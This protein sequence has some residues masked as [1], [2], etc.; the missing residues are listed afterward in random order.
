MEDKWTFLTHGDEMNVPVSPYLKDIQVLVCK[1]KLIE[2]GMGIHFF[3]NAAAGGNYILQPSF[4]NAFWLASLLP[5]NAPLSTMRIITTS[6]Y[7]LSEEYPIKKSMSLLTATKNLLDVVE[8]KEQV[9]GEET[10]GKVG[11]KSSG[12]GILT[13]D[14]MN[15]LVTEALD[16]HNSVVD[17]SSIMKTVISEESSMRIRNYTSGTPHS[18]A[19][20]HDP[21]LVASSSTS[22]QDIEHEKEQIAK[23]IRAETAVLRL[24]R[25]NAATDHSSII[26]NVDL[27]TGVI[28]YGTTNS[29]WYQ[30]GVWKIIQQLVINSANSLWL[31]IKQ[32]RNM[33][34]HMDAPQP[35]VTGKVVPN[36]QEAIDIVT[37]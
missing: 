30:L 4:Q 18:T 22:S 5:A 3:P 21:T 26:F 11:L 36:M 25:M 23:Y 2:G 24:G 9:N 28:G 10:S 31:P 8:Q 16:D 17:T 6:T 7:S 15:E 19:H 29:H 37:R 20:N 1:N 32:C 33:T 14:A 35:L 27:D 12:S 13:S 34:H